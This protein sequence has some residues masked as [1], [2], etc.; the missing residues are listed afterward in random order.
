MKL[1]YQF[2]LL[3]TLIV[4][5]S[6]AQVY[7]SPEAYSRADE[8]EIVAIIPP[9]VAIAAQRKVPAEAIKEQQ[10]VESINFQYEMH[11]W[12]LKRKSQ[13]KMWVEIL[14]LE[15]TNALLADAGYGGDKNYTPSELCHILGVDAIMTSNYA[16]SKPMSEGGALAVGVLFGVWGNTNNARVTVE[17][18]DGGISKLLW[19]Y[20]HE[21]GGSVGSSPSR[22]V[23]ALMRNASKKM[24]YFV[25]K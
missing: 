19:N 4:L 2:S 23:D 7:Y 15:T 16:L 25:R 20:K 24:P 5:S 13:G 10:K 21:I 18:Y 8:H 22:L 9:K 17:I 14:D 6:C 12:L 1:I 11:S 3:I